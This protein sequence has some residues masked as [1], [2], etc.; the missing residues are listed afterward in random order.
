MAGISQIEGNNS[1]QV[2][3]KSSLHEIGQLGSNFA[4]SVVELGELQWKLLIADSNAAYSQSV[5]S[6][7]TFLMASIACLAGVPVIA[8]G[9]AHG[10]HEWMAWPLWACYLGTGTLFLLLGGISAG[11]AAQQAFASF[12]CFQRSAKELSAN[13]LWMKNILRGSSSSL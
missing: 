1:M 12:Q 4:A 5:R 10:L 8:I 13:V 11:L 9:L 3:E 7:M 6:M 2:H